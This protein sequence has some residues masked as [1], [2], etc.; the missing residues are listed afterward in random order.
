[1]IKD[2]EFVSPESQG[3]RSED[4]LEFIHF[5]EYQKINIHSF[6]MARKGKIIAEGYVPPFHKDFAHR[7]YSSSK[8]FVSLAVGLLITEG[9]IT[10]QDKICDYLQD[11]IEKEQHPWI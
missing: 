11:Y 4:V 10:L 7:L 9:K 3:L 1:M 2:L 8:T 6:L 5:L